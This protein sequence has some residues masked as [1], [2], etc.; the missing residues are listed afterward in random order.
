MKSKNLEDSSLSITITDSLGQEKTLDFS[1][2]PLGEPL[3]H[4]LKRAFAGQLSHTLKSTQIQAFYAV[5]RFAKFLHQEGISHTTPLPADVAKIYRDWLAKTSPT[6]NAIANIN[7]VLKLL[8]WCTRNAPSILDKKTSLIIQKIPKPEQK[9]RRSLPKEALKAILSACYSDIDTTL[10]VRSLGERLLDGKADTEDELR[11]YRLLVT[12]MDIAHGD[13]PT[14]ESLRK[15]PVKI[16]QETMALGGIRHFNKLIWITAED[17]LPFYLAILLQCSG[18]PESILKLQRPCISPHPLRSDLE[19]ITWMKRRS[20]KEQRVDFPTN[21][22][23]SAPSLV[24]KLLLLNENM[25]LRCHP[26]ERNYLFIC[27]S[28]RGKFGTTRPSNLHLLLGAF[29]K[30][31][32]LVDFSF[33]DLRRATAAEHHRASK[34][35]EGAQARLNHAS[36]QTTA[37]Y[38]SVADRAKEH[39][40]VIRRFQGE[41]IQSGGKQPRQKDAQ[42]GTNADSPIAADTVFGFRCKDPYSGVAEGSRTGSL[43]LQ[44]TGCAT[45][46]GALIPL[47]DPTTVAR[48]MSTAQALEQARNRALQEGWWP[49]YSQ[50]YESTYRVLQVDLLPAIS[51]NMKSI[52]IG[53]MRPSEIPWLE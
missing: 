50:L 2:L 43:C 10:A 44:F 32:N 25:R 19:H 12:L 35:I 14:Y 5:I 47:D 24:R 16:Y 6:T 30:K 52:A 49:R 1:T 39:E 23:W 17:V 37:I 18:N 29:I 33:G 11:K 41:L 8:S 34:T 42:S 46:P 13:I 48:L 31:H 40:I 21:K 20:R 38:T 36:S 27:R 4:A 26:N 3:K 15:Q 28:G 53:I 7:I 51:E 45:C 22:E 9:E